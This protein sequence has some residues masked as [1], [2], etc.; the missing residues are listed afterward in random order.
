MPKVPL[1][2]GLLLPIGEFPLDSIQ[3]DPSISCTKKDL[4]TITSYNLLPKKEKSMVVP[5]RPPYTR[6]QINKINKIT[7][8][9]KQS[10]QGTPSI[11]KPPTTP[12]LIP[13]DSG[14]YILDPNSFIFPKSPLEPLLRAILTTH[15]N[16]TLTTTDLI[17]D[18]RNLRL[19]LGFVSANK[20][21][22]RINLE[23]IE[24]TICLSTWTS[25]KNHTNF[26]GKFEGY[27]HEFEKI[28]TWNPRYVRGSIIHNRVVKYTLGGI[29]IL[30]RYEV[31]ACLPGKPV[32]NQ[33]PT[34][35][36]TTTTNNNQQSPT[37]ISII[38]SG[39]LVPPHRI[40][41]IKTGPVTKRLD[42]SKTLS[43][44]WFSH[45]PILCTG[46]YQPDGTFLPAKTQ[47]MEK[48]GRLAGWE[49]DNADKIRK[50]VRV[51][52][53]VFE[54]VKAV[55]HKCALVHTGDGVLR[56]YQDGNGNGKGKG[57]SGELLGL[58]N[59]AP[60]V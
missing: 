48:E 37:G 34:T 19:L 21:P 47:N 1:L 54:V 36:S 30:L 58:W 16:Y 2:K 4:K 14:K 41:E 13:A 52:R 7:T 45:T 31:D 56:V 38:K 55:P 60:S 8:H 12:R 17:T 33:P 5:G 27:G 46:Q 3:P 35:T 59:I 15:P 18:R 24:S 49:R 57:V 20:K 53:M 44:M 29:Q 32:R 23:V 11:W 9:T 22:F 28:S 6:S 26:V 25:S 10:I 39:T 42:N 43:Q 40:I 51:L 50:L